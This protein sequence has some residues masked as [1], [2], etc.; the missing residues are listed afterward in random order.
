MYKVAK[1]RIPDDIKL[2]PNPVF[3][4]ETSQLADTN[5]T[6]AAA[7]CNDLSRFVG[8]PANESLSESLPHHKPG[9]VWSPARQQVLDA[10]KIDICDSQHLSVRRDLMRIART[11]SVWI[12]RFFLQQTEQRGITVSSPAYFDEIMEDWMNDPCPGDGTK[13]AGARLLEAFD[14]DEKH[15]AKDRMEVAALAT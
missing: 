14:K 3:L 13:G 11:S 5:A 8:L 9:K 7:F 2:L 12:R 1:L 15:A 10:A 6:R 4:F